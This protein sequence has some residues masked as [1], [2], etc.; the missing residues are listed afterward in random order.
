MLGPE[1]AGLFYVRREH[2]AKLRPI[3]IGSNSVVQENNYTHIELQ[4]KNTATR[5]EGGSPNCVPVSLALGASLDLLADIGLR[6]HRQRD[7]GNHQFVLP[8]AA[9]NRSARS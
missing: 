5:Y 4:L 3:G 7:P 1:G 6:C 2:L 9:G 8:A